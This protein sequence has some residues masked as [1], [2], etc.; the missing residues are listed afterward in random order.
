[1][2][3]PVPLKCP[4]CGYELKPRKPAVW[5]SLLFW[6]VLVIVGVIIWFI[7]NGLQ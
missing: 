6:L 7:A 5:P 4:N 2:D 1:M 3:E